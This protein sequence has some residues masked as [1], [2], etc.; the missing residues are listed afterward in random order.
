MPRPYECVERALA[1]PQPY[2][3]SL[4]YG[5]PAYMKLLACTDDSIRRGAHNGSEMGAFHLL[6][7]PQRE[8]DLQIRITEYL[9][10]GLEFGLIYQ[11]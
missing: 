2:F 6:L 4:R 11:N 10:V 5:H 8:S 9:P 7:A 1:S 3:A